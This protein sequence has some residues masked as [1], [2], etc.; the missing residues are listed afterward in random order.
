MEEEG[1]YII[2]VYFSVI[3]A[4]LWASL[5]AYVIYR[6]KIEIPKRNGKELGKVSQSDKLA[7]IVDVGEKISVGANAFLKREY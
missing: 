4:L 2:L 6:I 1:L 7:K 5:N 3:L